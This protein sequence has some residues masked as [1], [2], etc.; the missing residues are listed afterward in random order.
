ML[1]PQSEVGFQIHPR[2]IEGDCGCSRA[3][4]QKQPLRQELRRGGRVGG[5]LL[6]EHRTRN[7]VDDG[8][9][10]YRLWF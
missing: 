2:T 4:V 10:G 1:S 7:L 6:L 5:D 8:R 3:G 9:R